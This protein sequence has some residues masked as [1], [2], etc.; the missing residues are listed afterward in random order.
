MN[1]KQTQILIAGGLVFMAAAAR[2]VNAEM[3]LYNFAPV[4]ALGL[5]CGAV[6]KDKRYAFLFALLGQFLGD[7]YFGLFTSTQGFYGIAQVFTYV[8]LIAVTALGMLMRNVKALNVLAYTLGG[9]LL[10][11]LVSNFGYFAQGWNGY[12]FSGLTKTYIDAL[13][14]YRNSI[15]GDLIGST[16]LFGLYALLQRSLVGRTSKAI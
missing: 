9:S 10:F 11:F 12:S 4:A 2:V 7:I 1:N 5:F 13:P 3:H 14:F 8:A 6:V 15:V 16:L